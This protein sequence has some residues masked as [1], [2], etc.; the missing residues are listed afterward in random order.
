MNAKVRKKLARRQRRI[1]K[2]LDQRDRCGG[3][4]PMFAARTYTPDPQFVGTDSFFYKVTDPASAGRP[5]KP[6][7]FGVL[8]YAHLPV[9]DRLRLPLTLMRLR[10]AQSQPNE[11]FGDV[12]KRVGETDTSI[13]RFWDVF[14]RPVAAWGDEPASRGRK[15][16]ANER[17]KRTS[18]DG[19]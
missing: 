1:Q 8:R 10:S 18:A 19:G 11:S 3:A 9:K 4:Q 2:R 13:N 12:L 16:C 15:T 17:R 6:S 5:I 14:I 7:L